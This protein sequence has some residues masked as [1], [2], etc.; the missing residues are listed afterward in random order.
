[1]DPEPVFTA[2]AV[3]IYHQ[4]SVVPGKSDSGQRTGAALYAG[5]TD[6]G[7]QADMY[8][9]LPE[10]LP[11]A[12]IT[13]LLSHLKLYFTDGR[14]EGPW[15]A[16]SHDSWMI[17]TEASKKAFATALCLCSGRPCLSIFKRTLHPEYESSTDPK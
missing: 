6:V 7:V 4:R 15:R 2:N 14:Q 10:F 13:W 12:S 11:R 8:K 5:K 3:P 9:F 17:I 16:P 1:M